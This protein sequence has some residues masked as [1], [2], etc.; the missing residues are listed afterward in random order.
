MDIETAPESMKAEILSERKK[1]IYSTS[2][3]APETEGYIFTADLEASRRAGKAVGVKIVK[4]LPDFYGIFPS[5]WE[6][7]KTQTAKALAPELPKALAAAN[8][9][10]FLGNVYLLR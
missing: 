6:I 2:W 8:P 1:I 10:G 5:D 4:K 9:I 7:P 3:S